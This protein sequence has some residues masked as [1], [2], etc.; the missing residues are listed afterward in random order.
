MVVVLRGN[1]VL[2]EID[3]KN[4]INFSDDKINYL[5]FLYPGN[6]NEDFEESAPTVIFVAYSQLYLFI[7]VRVVI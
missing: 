1:F 6:V 2:L 3:N 7:L 4:V 5:K